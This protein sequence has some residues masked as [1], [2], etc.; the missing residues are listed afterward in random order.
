MK[1][2][3]TILSVLII[4][5]ILGFVF[6]KT[7][8][9]PFTT[10]DLAFDSSSQ[11]VIKELRSLQR[12][13]TAS[14]TIEKII[15]AGTEGNTFQEILYGD[16]LLLIAQGQVI[17]GIDLSKVEEKDLEISGTNL[18]LRLPAPEIL[19]SSLN[20]DQTR[21]YDRRMGMLSKGN[22]DLETRARQEAE[23]IITQAACEGMILEKAGENAQQQLGSLF[24]ALG[25]TSV[26]IEIPQGTCQ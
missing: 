25:Y 22:K 14:Y 26:V 8:D 16:H 3:L 9:N 7:T 1:S 24:S 5:S 6:I 17:A 2:I 18:R 10:P 13:E 12:L 19:V 11:T 4:I 21:V 23:R 15:E 20:N